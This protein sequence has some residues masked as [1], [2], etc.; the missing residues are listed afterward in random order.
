M[1]ATTVGVDLAKNVFVACVADC[2]GR[3]VERREFNR[4]GFLTWLGTLPAGTVIGMEACGSA[5][6]WGRQLQAMGHT[7]H[8]LPPQY[9]K[10]FVIGQ[11]N[12]AN[13][14]AAI[15]A[16]MAH[17]GIPRVAIKTILQQDMQALHRIRSM[18]MKQRTAT[19]NQ[20]Q[21][22]LSWR[23]RID[24]RCAKSG[25]ARCAR[26]DANHGSRSS[27]WIRS[28]QKSEVNPISKACMPIISSMRALHWI[29]PLSMFHCQVPRPAPSTANAS[30]C[31][32]TRV[33]VK[34]LAI[35]TQ[36]DNTPASSKM[37]CTSTKAQLRAPW[38]V[39][40]LISRFI[41][42]HFIWR[43]WRILFEEEERS[44]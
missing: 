44:L 37:G 36:P 2:A 20:T 29:R 10:P 33:S 9:V 19:I 7:V 13:D 8:L 5:H 1:D 34:S 39:R 6:H 21:R 42:S 3:I 40:I 4:A 28:T 15:C 35:N 18:K 30:I 31:C 25:L 26:D 41:F 17:P 22:P 23:R 16:A 27:G 32:C 12:D 43:I 24:M 14:A 38:A 11:K